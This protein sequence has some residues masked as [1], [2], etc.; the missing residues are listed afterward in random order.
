MSNAVIISNT[1][2]SKRLEID[3]K[4]N[5]FRDVDKVYDYEEIKNFSKNELRELYT[6]GKLSGVINKMINDSILI[7]VNRGKYK[8][9][10]S[11][12]RVDIKGIMREVLINTMNEIQKGLSKVSAVELSDNDFILL[13]EA[14][15]TL[16][17]LQ[18]KYELFE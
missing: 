2:D 7:R 14:R 3:L 11:E 8:L 9:A 17:I 16:K 10:T 6:D 4:E 15:E 12:E 5:F 13:T 18:G 1:S